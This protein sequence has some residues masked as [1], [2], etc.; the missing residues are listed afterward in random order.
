[1]PDPYQY[2]TFPSPDHLE[3]TR[4]LHLNK[5]QPS[6]PLSGTLTTMSVTN[7]I[8]FEALSYVWGSS[9]RHDT[10]D[11]NGKVLQITESIAKALRCLRD[12]VEPRVLWADQVC[13]NQNDLVERS[14]QVRHMS[15]IYQ[16]AKKV[17]VWL[18]DDEGGHAERAF[19]L[20]RSLAAVSRDAL[21][22]RQFVEKQREGVLDWLPVENWLSMSELFKRPWFDRMWVLQEIGTDAPSE[23]YWGDAVLDWADV[24]A[25]A[26][27]LKDHGYALRREYDL[28]VWKPWYMDKLFSPSEY[29]SKA[30]CFT[31]ELHRARWQVASD[32]RDH[33]F[34]LLGHPAAR[35]GPDA[36]VVPQADY[37]KSVEDVYLDFTAR[38]LQRGDSLMIL[39]TVQHENEH[40]CEYSP[41]ASS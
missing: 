1:M 32:P 25:A 37:T 10:I 29:M 5:G 36:A 6:D 3:L 38:V 41:S 19:E 4:V 34:A 26:S 24:S 17:L 22:L 27:L 40:L 13:I 16:K 30:L 31:F 9:N 39:N 23:L 20:V 11:F 28:L 8:P 15:A 18:G 12:T 35:G 33:I 21:L 2:T 14:Q 7:P